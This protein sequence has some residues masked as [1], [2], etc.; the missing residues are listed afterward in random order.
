MKPDDSIL[1]DALIE[2]G[3]S[4]QAAHRAVQEV[5]NIA[6]HNIT[7]TVESRIAESNSKIESMQREMQHFATKD[8]VQN[9]KVWWLVTAGAVG[10]LI[11]THLSNLAN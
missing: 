5:L 9:T 10:G 4:A 7:T 8:Y 1:F 2:A 3:A 6:G 11:G